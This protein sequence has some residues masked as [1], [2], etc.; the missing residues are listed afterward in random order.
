MT[1][2]WVH[3]CNLGAFSPNPLVLSGDLT[4]IPKGKSATAMLGGFTYFFPL[5]VGADYDCGS[6]TVQLV[7]DSNG[8]GRF[9]ALAPMRFRRMLDSGAYV[10]WVSTTDYDDGS[11]TPWAANNDG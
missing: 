5:G 1:V 4:V 9:V 10:P 2:T 3:P 7:P 11:Y 8:P 6:Y